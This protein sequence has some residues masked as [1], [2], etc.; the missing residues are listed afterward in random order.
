M[1]SNIELVVRGKNIDEFLANAKKSWQ[2]FINDPEADLPHDAE[3][4]AKE[5]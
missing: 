4:N 2:G 1:R 3:L 5:D